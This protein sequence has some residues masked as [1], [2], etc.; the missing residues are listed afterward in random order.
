MDIK[1]ARKEIYKE[2]IGNGVNMRKDIREEMHKVLNIYQQT[3]GSGVDH[4]RS[5]SSCQ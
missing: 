1:P 4:S 3:L 2:K 5:N